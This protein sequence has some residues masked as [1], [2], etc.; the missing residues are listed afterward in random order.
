M[1]IFAGWAVRNSRCH[2]RTENEAVRRVDLNLRHRDRSVLF[3]GKIRVPPPQKLQAFV[4][5]RET[6]LAA[7][8]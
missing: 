8:V 1:K 5:R 4:K 7:L 2:T 6:H 3:G